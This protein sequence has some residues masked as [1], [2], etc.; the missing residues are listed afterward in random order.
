MRKVQFFLALGL[1]LLSA[2]LFANCIDY[3]ELGDVVYTL[4]GSYI[5]LNASEDGKVPVL[6]LG[7]TSASHVV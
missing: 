4:P 6:G 5:H 7:A 2:G 1:T 3:S